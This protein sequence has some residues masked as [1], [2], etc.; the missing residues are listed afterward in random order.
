MSEGRAASAG[1]KAKPVVGE[2]AAIAHEL[3]TPLTIISHLAASLDNNL[4]FDTQAERQQALLRIRLSA[5][6]TLRL[7]QS[8]TLSNRLEQT[9][10]LPFTL[11]LGP[12]NTTQ[13]CQ[14]VMHELSP[15]ANAHGQQLEL[16][17]PMSPQLIVGNTDLLKSVFF[18]L[19]DNAI[20]HNPPQT[21]VMLRVRRRG[22][23]VRTCVQ[24]NGPGPSSAE[25]NRLRRTLGIAL[26]PLSGRAN[27]SGLGLYIASHMAQAMGGK[28]GIGRAPVG[29]DFHVDLL[30]SKQLSLL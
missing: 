12:L 17:A 24:D 11:E 6:R 29:A 28:V 1:D 8:L 20:K 16:Q 9:D 30:Y 25:L 26:Q 13:L 10:Q 5:E 15:L 7:V 23:V 4:V 14:E 18:N 2:L 27:S 19:I 22:D 3:K 21:T